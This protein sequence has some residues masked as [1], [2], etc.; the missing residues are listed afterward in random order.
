MLL[1][2]SHHKRDIPV[3]QW[4]ELGIADVVGK[5][6]DS[7]CSGH[8]GRI[9]SPSGVPFDTRLVCGSQWKTKRNRYWTRNGILC[10]GCLP[11]AS[12]AEWDSQGERKNLRAE[13]KQRQRLVCEGM[14]HAIWLTSLERFLPGMPQVGEYTERNP[15]WGI[16]WIDWLRGTTETTDQWEVAPL[17]EFKRY[18]FA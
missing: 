10:T 15:V 9:M 5:H 7:G 3:R 2:K 1:A 17:A 18:R 12:T 11:S 8:W 16:D 4:V 14:R 13:V 6:W